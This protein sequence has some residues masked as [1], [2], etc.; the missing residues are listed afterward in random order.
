MGRESDWDRED[1]NKISRD[2]D[3]TEADRDEAGKNGEAGDKDE[4][5]RNKAARDEVRKKYGIRAGLCAF[6]LLFLW[7]IASDAYKMLPGFYEN[8][9]RVGVFSDSY[10]KVQNGYS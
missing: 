6:L 3:S 2:K 10:W 7:M 8:V 5:E 9:I 1:K 4:A